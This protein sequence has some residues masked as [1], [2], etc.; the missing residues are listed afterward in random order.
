[1]PASIQH[2]LRRARELAREVCGFSLEH[3]DDAALLHKLDASAQR[4][5]GLARLIQRVEVD[6]EERQRFVEALCTHE[7]RFFRHDYQFRYLLDEHLPAVRRQ[8]DQGQRERRVR[9]WSVA[10]STG[11]E[12]TSLAVVLCEA[13]PEDVGCSVLAT[14]VSR[15]VL[16]RARLLRWPIEFAQSIPEDLRRSYFLKG[17]GKAAGFLRPIPR[18]CDC[19]QFE[20][21]NLIE[22]GAAFG[23]AFDL[24]FCRNVLIYFDA[25][26]R[27]AILSRL[28]RTLAPQGLLVTGPSEGVLRTAEPLEMLVPHVYRRK[29][30]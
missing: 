15:Q 25:P 7:T 21:L 11:E 26:T 5:G 4:L 18:V 27:A 23:Q 3:V 22:G 9:A 1:M 14:D 19:I 2:G 17:V 30:R 8:M 16:E 10:C 24:V 12:P 28:V 20:C 13:F 29:E 6:P